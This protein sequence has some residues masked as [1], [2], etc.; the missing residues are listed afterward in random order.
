MA[1]LAHSWQCPVPMNTILRPHPILLLILTAFQAVSIQSLHADTFVREVLRSFPAEM[2]PDLAIDIEAARVSV[3]A[4]DQPVISI[5]VLLSVKAGSQ[6]DADAAFDAMDLSF[7]DSDGTVHFEARQKKRGLFSWGKPREPQIA[8]LVLCPQ[9]QNLSIDT[10]SGSI[11]LTGTSGSASLDTGSGKIVA[12]R[13][14]GTVS[15]D[16]GSGNIHLTG[17]QGNLNADTGSG[18]IEVADLHGFL[19]ADTGSGRVQVSG[20]LTGFHVDTGSGQVHL[21]SSIPLETDSLVD[22]GSGSISVSLPNIA[23]FHLQADSASG[24]ITNAFALT[25]TVSS[26]KSR[27]HARIGSNG[28]DLVL[29]AGSGSISVLSLP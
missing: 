18:S 23:A 21:S 15:A 19:Q 11:E 12:S 13:L 29:H 5:Q 3:T 24:P 22:T 20:A 28:P 25:E 14:M 7:K 1:V 16:T 4:H 9:E 26:S 8:V 2:S 6:E 17:L 10:G 27:L